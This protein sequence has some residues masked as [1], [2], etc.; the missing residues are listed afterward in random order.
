MLVNMKG[1]RLIF[2][3]LQWLGPP[4]FTAEEQQFAREIHKDAVN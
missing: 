3:K 2:D 4:R 1:Q